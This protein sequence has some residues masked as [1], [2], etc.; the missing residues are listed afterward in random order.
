MDHTNPY[1]YTD[2]SRCGQFYGRF[3]SRC[4]LLQVINGWLRKVRIQF[5]DLLPVVMDTYDPVTGI[6]RDFYGLLRAYYGKLRFILAFT[7]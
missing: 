3:K 7:C 1:K 5:Y 6:L 2:A 4:E